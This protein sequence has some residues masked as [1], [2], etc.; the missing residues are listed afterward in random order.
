MR[1]TI[2]FDFD[3]TLADTLSFKE[4]L[5]VSSD[6]SAVAARMRDFIFPGAANV[7]DRLKADGWNLTLVTIG[8]PAWQESKVVGSGLVPYFSR[9]IYTSDPKE[10]HVEE[11]KTWPQPLFFVNDH[12]EEVDALS[13][14]LPESRMIVVAGPKPLPSDPNIPVCATLEEVYK[15]ISEV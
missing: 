13:Q 5:A 11:Y 14:V 10:S 1:G 4:A 2:V 6:P 8:E 15:R 9:V 7:L 12:G 3:Y